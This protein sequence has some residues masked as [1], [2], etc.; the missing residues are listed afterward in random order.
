M[1]RAL[2]DGRLGGVKV[3]AM[4]SE[5]PQPNTEPANT[6]W[7]SDG[8]LPDLSAVSAASVLVAGAPATDSVLVK[9]LRRI[10]AELDEGTESLAAFSNFAS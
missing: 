10:S 6:A 1:G 2:G 3:W 4:I 9:A 7:A 8:L 5:V